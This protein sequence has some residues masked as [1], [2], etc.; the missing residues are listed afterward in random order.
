MKRG[1]LFLITLFVLALPQLAAAGTP[2]WHK[3]AHWLTWWLPAWL[4]D[5]LH[6]LLGVAGG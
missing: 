3:I 1:R 5:L 6:K 4:V 2:W